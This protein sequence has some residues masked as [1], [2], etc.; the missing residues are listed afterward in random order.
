MIMYVVQ[1]VKDDDKKRMCPSTNRSDLTLLWDDACLKEQRRK[2]VHTHYLRRQKRLA[3]MPRYMY[4]EVVNVF[5]FIF[6]LLSFIFIT[7]YEKARYDMC[8]YFLIKLCWCKVI[9]KK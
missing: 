5:K 8:I 1:Y 9:L 4:V 3:K 7:N 6:F 2:K